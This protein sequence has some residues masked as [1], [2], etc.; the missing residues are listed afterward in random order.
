[1]RELLSRNPARAAL[2]AGDDVT[3][4]DAFRELRALVD[5]GELEDAVTV[6]V[7]SDDGPP[8]IVEQADVV[9]DGIDGVRQVL[10]ELDER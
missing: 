2:Y 7:R 1:V 4:L 8:E 5:E 9:V 10:A 3:D 6:G